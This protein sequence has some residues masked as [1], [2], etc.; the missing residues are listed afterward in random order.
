MPV[1][2]KGKPLSIGKGTKKDARFLLETGKFHFLEILR[3]MSVS[4]FVNYEMKCNIYWD[5]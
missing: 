1:Y 3:E 5:C 4:F 2:R